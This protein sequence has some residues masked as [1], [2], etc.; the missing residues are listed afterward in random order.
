M[1]KREE[2]EDL[3]RNKTTTF[4]FW[5]WISTWYDVDNIFACIDSWEEKLC[6]D[7]I[8]EIKELNIKFNSSIL[9]DFVN[10]LDN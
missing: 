10:K 4:I 7:S 2:L 6:E 1:T 5:Y 8:Q 9:K 3:L